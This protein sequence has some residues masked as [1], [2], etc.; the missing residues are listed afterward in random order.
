VSTAPLVEQSSALPSPRTPLVGRAQEVASACALLLDAAVPLLTLTGP[1]GVG[2]TRLAVAIARDVAPSFADGVAFV[3]LSPL[4]DPAFVIPAIAQAVGVRGDGADAAR[5]VAALRPRQLLLVLDN[6]EHVLEAVPQVGD[7][8]AACPALQILATSRAPLRLR[9][10]HLLPAPPLTLPALASSPAELRSVAA[11]ELFVARARATDPTFV[12]TEANAADVAAICTRLDGLPLAIELAA[13]RLR[14]LSVPALLALL[15][16]RLRLLTG[17]ERDRPDRQRAMRDTIAWSHDLLTLEDQRLFR[18]LAVFAGGFTASAAVAVGGE[19]ALTVLDRVTALA[20]QSLLRRIDGP[21]GEARWALLETVREFGLEQLAA[22]GEAD[23]T[24][25]R[26]L[27]WCLKVVD[28]AWAPRAAVPADDRATLRLDAERDNLRAGLTWA[29]ENEQTDAA[30]RLT[31]GLAEYWDLRGD[32]TEGRAWT[33]RALALPMGSSAHRA[34][35]HYGATV[36]AVHQGDLAKAS[37]HATTGLSLAQDQGDPLDLLRAEWALALT[38][39]RSGDAAQHA[40]HAEQAASLARE[41]GDT[42]WLGWALLELGEATRDL[43]DPRQGA[44][45]L[46]EAIRLLAS[47]DDRWGEMHV[48]I[49]LAVIVHAA[50]DLVRAR[51]L[52][53]RGVTLAVDL[54]SPWGVAHAFIG[55]AAVAAGEGRDEQAAWLLGAAENL[56]A[57]NDYQFGPEL[58]APRDEANRMARTH[59]GEAGFAAA[60]EAGRTLSLDDAVALALAG[61]AVEPAFPASHQPAPAADA[62]TNREREILPLLVQRWTDKEIADALFLSPRTVSTHVTNIFNKLGVNNR[63][64]AAAIATRR[65]LV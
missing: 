23:E 21:D 15:T 2:K 20:D 16:E 43:G 33:D 34:P 52:F 30:L 28:G 40:A 50:G 11:V 12:L 56:R 18:R 14:V 32:F 22:S 60:W 36:L 41:I 1:G 42:N 35:A 65:G 46:E 9:E 31:G 8:L 26:H 54:A 13:A 27:E 25:D 6:C 47:V 57:S 45:I 51:S 38:A 63:R 5:V 3:D 53:Q 7:V 44:E 4:R 37:E 62:L 49:S 24:R 19:D 10:E 55:L 39:G 29:I 59:L 58:L 17:G 64:E 61:D 48:T